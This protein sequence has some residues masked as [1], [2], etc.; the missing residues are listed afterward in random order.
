M[1]MMCAVGFQKPNEA[2]LSLPPTSGL[3]PNRITFSVK[4]SPL[5]RPDG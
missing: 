1:R 5:C 3:L 4:L 2:Y